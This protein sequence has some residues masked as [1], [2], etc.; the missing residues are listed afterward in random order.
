MVRRV[1]LLA[2]VL[3]ACGI[4]SVAAAQQS[5]TWANQ[6]NVAVR[7]S[8]LEKTGGCQG[9]DD[10]GAISR[11]T[12]RSGDGFV[13]FTVGEDYT[14]WLA[15]L[16]HADGNTRFGN[17]DFAIR[18]NANGWA[19]VMENGQY[20][21][22]DTEYRSGDTF[23]VEVV[24]GRV[25][26]AKNGQVMYISQKRPAYPLVLDV[27]LGTVGAT[28]RNARIGTRAGDLA[29]FGSRQDQVSRLDRFDDYDIDN[30]GVITRREWTGTSREFNELD[31]NRDGRITSREMARAS[32]FENEPEPV[33][34][35]GDFI[36]VSAT[37]RWTDTGL[38][39]RAGDTIV[40]EAEGTIQMSGDPNDTAS[41]AGSRR[42]APDAPLRQRAAGS[43]IA[44]IG[45][46][47]PI[48]VGSRNT[49]T[50]VPVSGRLF[51]GVNDDYLGDNS[52]EFRVMVTIEPR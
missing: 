3:L 19:D 16:S 39:V 25:R 18:F 38:T 7:G 36:A 51:L 47:A 21:G 5:V 4:A 22:G 30:N 50:R 44:R 20:A 34:T 31:L 9:C 42:R 8:S 43:L 52:G 41:P 49:V 40:F 15:G 35:A 26:Y 2:T 6:V 37:E 1:P 10:A 23:R 48:V 12:I 29:G 27:A 24:G 14:F 46:S 13:E 33:A 45:N 11:Q 17:I 32:R 28:V